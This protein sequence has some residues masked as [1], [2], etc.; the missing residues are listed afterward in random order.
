M[1]GFASFH[2]ACGY[3]AIHNG[4]I[5]T[6]AD[7]HCITDRFLNPAGVTIEC[8]LLID[9]ALGWEYKGGRKLSPEGWHEKSKALHT[10]AFLYYEE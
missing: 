6:A 3:P 8:G 5:P 7:I 2:E 1:E 4:D 9:P 10:A